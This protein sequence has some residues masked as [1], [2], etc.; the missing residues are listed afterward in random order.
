MGEGVG[1]VEPKKRKLKLPEGGFRLSYG[2]VL[3]EIEVAYEECGAELS[4]NNAVYILHALTGDAHVAGMRPGEDSPSGWWEGMVG[5]GRAID[6]NRFHVI[7]ANVLGGCSGTTGPMSTNPDTGKP[8]GSDFPRYSFDDAVDV[9][10]MLLRELGV[11]KLAALIGGSYGGIQAVNWATRFPDDMEKLILVATSASL[12]TQ[13]LAFDV[14]GKNSITE[15][16]LWK[17][18]DYYLEGDGK[19]PKNGLASARQLAHISYLSRE[20]LQDKFER[21]L[22][23]N[24]VNAPEAERKERDRLFKTYFQIESY[25]D[26]QAKKFVNRFDANSYLHIVSSMDEA[27]PAKEFGS[28]DAAMARVSAKTL[29]VSYGGDVLFPVWQSLEM[30]SAM[31]KAGGDVSYCHLDYG[32]GHDG[33]LT[34]IDEL[35]KLVGGFLCGRTVK[36]MKWQERLYRNVTRMI[37]EGSRVLDIGCGDGSLLNVLRSVKG[38]K[39]DG[40]EIDVEKFEEALADGHNVLYDDV[41]DGGI[42][43]VPDGRYDTAI[44]S[45]TLQEVKNPRGLLHEALRVADEAIVTFPNFAAYRIRLTLGFTGRLPVSKQLPFQWYDTPNI[46]CITLKDFRALCKAEGIE[47]LETRAESR[48]PAGKLMLALGLKNLGASKIIARIGK[49]KK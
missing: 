9:F 19:G 37:K 40:I 32:V 43:T 45:D 48:H 33:F 2:G 42:D 35:S 10:R 14:M 17:G 1:T 8:Y 31:E 4:E 36:T 44:V 13:A 18:G 34:H 16:P 15:N 3:K 39:G 41:D 12:N 46:H 11:K 49:A 7:C 22:Q 28:L 21:R 25:L 23:D 24:F 30:V 47:I 6:T 5:P 27:D 20:H 26:Y 38:V 29:V